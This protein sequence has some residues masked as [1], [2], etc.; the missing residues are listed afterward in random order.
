MKSSYI[1]IRTVHR[2]NRKNSD[3]ILRRSARGILK[4]I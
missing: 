2:I 3:L 4:S 1:K